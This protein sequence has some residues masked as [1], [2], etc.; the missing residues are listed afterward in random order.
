MSTVTDLFIEEAKLVSIADAL[1]IIGL[2]A[3][4]R[5]GEY[6]GPCPISGGKDRFSYNPRKNVWNCRGCGVGGHGALGLAG[7]VLG[8]DLRRAEDYL[9]ACSAVLGRPVPDKSLCETD[10]QKQAREKATQQKRAAAQKKEQERQRQADSYRQKE[11]QKAVT[12]W[13]DARILGATP[14]VLY[15]KLR[16]GALIPSWP[17][18][19]SQN[20]PYFHDNKTIYNGPAMIAPFV[21]VSGEIIG[22]HITWLNLNNPPKYRPDIVVVDQSGQSIHLP[23]K[24]MR[25][26]KKGGLIPLKGF[27][28]KDSRFYADQKRHRMVVG[29]GIET[30]LA[31]CLADG[32][33]DDTIYAAAGDL[34]NLTGPADPKSR[35]QHPEIFNTAKDGGKCPMWVA[36]PVPLFHQN[37]ADSIWVPDHITDLVLIADGDSELVMTASAM[38]RAKA[39]FHKDGRR[40][41]VLWPPRGHD[42]A[43]MM[44]VI[45]EGHHN[46]Q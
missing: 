35:F 13:R 37:S 18:R 4:L 25:G 30:V 2:N 38:A 34:G 43:D 33:R 10:A 11:R 24:K 12:K 1:P 36:G 6:M 45:N 26:S 41:P 32:E 15:I 44:A 28:F 16:C 7:H 39:R 40:I 31:T 5:N 29:E 23:T 22:C 3:P 9:R 17:L 19:L 27:I 42:I 20:E 14:F 21:A 8:L 46:E